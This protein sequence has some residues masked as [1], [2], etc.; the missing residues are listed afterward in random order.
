ME[1]LRKKL[2]SDIQFEHSTPISDEAGTLAEKEVQT[3][4]QKP[5]AK[6]KQDLSKEK[7][8]TRFWKFSLLGTDHTVALKKHSRLKLF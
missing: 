7:S 3:N 6:K 5:Q 1:K 2:V 4:K 8:G